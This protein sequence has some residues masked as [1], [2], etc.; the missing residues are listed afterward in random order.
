MPSRRPTK[1]KQRHAKR[2]PQQSHTPSAGQTVRT[3]APTPDNLRP[4]QPEEEQKLQPAKHAYRSENYQQPANPYWQIDK[5]NIVLTLIFSGAV[6]IFTAFSTYYS[7]KQWQA[8]MESL[9]DAKETRE[10]ENRAWVIVTG[11]QMAKEMKVGEMPIVNFIM[12]NK[13]NTPA[14]NARITSE[15]QIRDSPVPDGASVT[16]RGSM[17]AATIAPD[18]EVATFAPSNVVLDE[19]TFAAVSK[20]QKH[21]YA[22][23]VLQYE[24]IFGKAHVT[25]YCV[26]YQAY[27]T[28]FA[29]CENNNSMN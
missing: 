18:A 15:V 24:D 25:S 4:L 29:P 22:W 26:V 11:A 10:I 5:L 23:G 16:V 28:H 2:Q 12:A 14:R 3:D 7:S 19:S 9:K 8:V 17:S 27:S 20:G 1:N 6:A 21:L 13:G